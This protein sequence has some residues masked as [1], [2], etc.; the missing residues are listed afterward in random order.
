MTFTETQMFAARS[1]IEVSNARGAID[2]LGKLSDNIVGVGPV[3]IGLEGVLEFIPVVG[4]IYSLAAGGVMVL[5]GMRAH[6]PFLTLVWC[7]ILILLRT[8]VGAIKDI[9]LLGLTPLGL[10]GDVAAGLFRAHRMS[11]QM[12]VKAIDETLY[13]EGRRGH[14][15]EHPD[16][17]AAL[18]DVRA[19][20]DRRRV[21]FLG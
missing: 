19:G 3:G 6:V 11:A 14:T 16:D 20:A 15:P 2:R 12:M 17:V 1:H 4:E 7:T 5:Q 21:V 10:G 9:P 8:L 13:I 18:G